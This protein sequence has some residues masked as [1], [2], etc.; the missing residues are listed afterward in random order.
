MERNINQERF[1]GLPQATSLRRLRGAPQDRAALL[2]ALLSAVEGA[3]VR[4][5]SLDGWRRVSHTLGRRVRI[6]GIEGIAQAV[7]DDGALIV[8]G[9]AVLAGDVELVAT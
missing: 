3:D 4:S 6:N 9:Q 8:D 5:G 1:D 2:A 7:R